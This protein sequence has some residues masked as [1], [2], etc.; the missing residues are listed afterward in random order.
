MARI[1]SIKPEFCVSEQLA[2]CSPNARLVFVLMWMFCDDQ[3][4]HPA[5]PKTLKAEIFPMDDFTGEQVAGWVGELVAAGLLSEYTVGSVPYWI[6]T[7]WDKHQKIDK[8]S[9]KH[10]RPVGED[11]PSPLRIVA[12]PSPPESSRVE[13][14]RGEGRSPKGSRLPAD[15]RLSSEQIE[16]A[17]GAQPSW[18]AE[19][20]LKVGE[21]FRDYWTSKPG[22]EAAKLDWDATWR[23]WVRREHAVKGGDRPR[24]QFAGAL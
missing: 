23:N 11:S 13:G 1:R 14:S 5:K 8:P 15:W 9:A 19:H 17:L 7:G 3:G 22:R 24:D 6:V 12:E 4:I 21:A 16:W 20:T 10:P 2:E 18:D